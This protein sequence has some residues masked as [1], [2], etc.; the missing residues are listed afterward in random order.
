MPE[1]R[2]HRR[3]VRR[4]RKRS[5]HRRVGPRQPLTARIDVSIVL[6]QFV[7]RVGVAVTSLGLILACAAPV[8]APPKVF[9]VQIDARASSF[10][11]AASV[12]F[13][14]EIAVHA[15]DTVRF[16]AVDRGEVHT[17]TFGKLVDAALETLA[18]VPPSAPRPTLESLGLPPVLI[19][20]PPSS[21]GRTATSP[22]FVDS[23]P[24]PGPD[25]CRPEQQVQPDLTGSQTL[26]NSGYLA[27]GEIFAVRLA[28]SMRP[29][30]YGFICLLHGPEMSGR[31]VVE[32]NSR[33]VA[34]PS[35]VVARGT[36]ELD[37]IVRRLVPLVD[38]A[39][40]DV[41]NAT[42]FAGIS[43]PSIAH[44]QATVFRPAEL[45]VRRGEPVTWTITGVHTIT[46]NAPQDAVG[47]VVRASDR[48]WA[49]NPRL[50]A[51][52][53]S[54]DPT[55]G[56]QGGPRVI[57]SGVWNGRGFRNSGLINA[58]PGPRI[59]RVLFGEPGTYSYKCLLHPDMEGTVKVTN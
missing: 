56:G 41:P 16:T 52:E 26:F 9:D 21:L 34:S 28:A 18:K 44:T 51:A 13:P 45:T 10:S 47:L 50:L 7:S 27:G 36:E 3:S 11:L 24:T 32:E 37:L 17:V 59:Y 40:R 38:A 6:R 46:F 35:E 43:A 23:R 29:G 31:I 39:V 22:C 12:F 14:H 5:V 48:S 58:D 33:P 55:A 2:E 8:P 15:G 53:Q 20:E 42:I 19:G 25:G 54:P 30:T 4:S 1:K 57:E 49:L